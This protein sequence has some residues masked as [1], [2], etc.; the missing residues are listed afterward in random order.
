MPPLPLHR[1]LL[2]TVSSAQAEVNRWEPAVAAA[3][4]LLP[5]PTRWVEGIKVH[6]SDEERSQ[7]AAEKLSVRLDE[8]GN[9]L[10]EHGYI[11]RFNGSQTKWLRNR[12]WLPDGDYIDND[13]ENSTD[14]RL[15]LGSA[16]TFVTE[17]LRNKIAAVAQHRE[18]EDGGEVWWIQYWDEDGQKVVN[19]EVDAQG[20][21]LI[22]RYNYGPGLLDDMEVYRYEYDDTG[23][24]QAESHYSS[25]KG[26]GDSK[27]VVDENTTYTY[28]ENGDV[29]F[30]TVR[31]DGTKVRE[32]IRHYD[33]QGRF[34][35]S[36]ITE[37][38]EDSQTRQIQQEAKYDPISRPFD[39]W[40]VHIDS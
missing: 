39:Y 9:V 35:S 25:K 6:R 36:T 8:A 32:G 24:L 18:L 5:T 14:R 23:R 20:R 29:V 11:T 16:V 26:L 31:D 40:D 27:T 33:E 17:T 7:W 38:L 22:A 15:T 28:L 30:E 1:E 19:E 37:L 2:E 21:L 34:V 12:N 3:N 4:P 10:Q 13:P